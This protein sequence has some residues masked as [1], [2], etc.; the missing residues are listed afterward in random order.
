T[1]VRRAI[2]DEGVCVTQSVQGKDE[3]AL[4]STSSSSVETASDTGVETK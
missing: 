2:V 4:L 3:I 1:T